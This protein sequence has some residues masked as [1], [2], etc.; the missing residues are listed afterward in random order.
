MKLPRDIRGEELARLLGHYGYRITRQ[1]GS[2]IRLTSSQKGMEHPI[3]IP[4]HKQ[5]KIGIL[6]AILA[7]VARYLEMD[8]QE[9]TKG[10]FGG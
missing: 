2:H 3:T 10:L 1:T 6:S 7:D 5:V 4:A 8:R 9:L